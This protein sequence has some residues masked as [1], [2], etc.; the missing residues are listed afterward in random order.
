MNTL[1]TIKIAAIAALTA[2]AFS[3]CTE[4]MDDWGTDASYD[5]LFSPTSLS[6]TA[7]STTAE[8]EFGKVSG[9]EKYIL[10]V[11]TDSLSNDATPGNVKTYELTDSPA[12][13]DGLVGDTYYYMRVRGVANGRPDSN[14]LY[15]RASNGRG[16]FHTAK[17]QIMLPVTDADRGQDEITVSWTPGAEV[18]HLLVHTADAE[19]VTI[20]LDAAAK[21]ACRYTITGLN[22]S[23]TYVISIWLGEAQRGSVTA[24]TTAAAPKG[25]YIYY[26]PA[27]VEVLDN[28]MM[29]SIAEQAQAASS[30]PAAYSATIVIPAGATI[31]MVGVSESGDPAAL[32]MA[33]G[34]SVTFF[35]AAGVQPTVKLSKSIDLGGTHA[36]VRF[37]NI[38][39]TDGGCQYLFNQANAANVEELSFV[40]CNFTF[41]S[42]S[43]SLVRVQ[44]S[45]AVSIGTIKVD[46]AIIKDLPDSYYMFDLRGSAQNI[47]SFVM[48]N[49]TAY[50]IG[51]FF[52]NTGND[53]TGGV[54]VNDCTFNDLIASGRYFIDCNG[55]ATN[56]NMAGVIIGV[57]KAGARGIRTAGEAVYDNMYQTADVLV[58]ATEEKP[59]AKFSS[60]DMK[61]PIQE[62]TAAQLFADPANGDFSLSIENKVGDPRWY[63][64]AAE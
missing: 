7:E 26:M 64:P 17:E 9:V 42:T 53:M 31:D 33:D 43:R 52:Q 19:D 44:G 18:S 36:Y 55:K 27:G 61:L 46:N 51:R 40:D 58:E 37:N 2:G 39:F 63:K 22:P 10:E 56:I 5:R 1:K 41:T 14:W 15:Y 32:K 38:H 34:M 20:Q 48:T 30:D 16:C 29:K 50:N 62:L 12:T 6:V 60:N 35:G 54:T 28:E 25:D 45:N 57:L 24:S 13:I 11:S 49:T 8:V 47:G 21:E 23:T 3:A 59:A 4:T